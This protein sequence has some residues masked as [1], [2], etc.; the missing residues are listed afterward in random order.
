MPSSFV[1]QFTEREG[2]PNPGLELDR[3]IAQ[4]EPSDLDLRE[5]AWF[6]TR[7]GVQWSRAEGAKCILFRKRREGGIDAIRATIG[8]MSRDTPDDDLVR[9]FYVARGFDFDVWWKVNGVEREPYTSI[10]DV[11]GVSEKSGSRASSTFKGSA[12]FAWWNFDGRALAQVEDRDANI[13]HARCLT[14]RAPAAV[15]VNGPPPPS[16]LFGVDF[17]GGL[18]DGRGNRKI[19]VAKW[20]RSA[21]PGTIHLRHGG[22]EQFGRAHLSRMVVE[23]GGWW[24]FDFPFGIALETAQALELASWDAWLDWCYGDGDLA[25]DYPTRRRDDARGRI[26]VHG[27]ARRRGVDD[28]WGTTWFPLFQQLY[29][30]TIRGAAE[31]LRPLRRDHLHS[32]CVY[33]W[34]EFTGQRS[35]VCEG[36]PGATICRFLGLAATGYKGR[37]QARRAHRELIIARLIER[38]LPIS[39]EQAQRAIADVEGDAVDALVLLESA[40]RASELPRTDWQRERDRLA[41]CDQEIEGW[42]P[43]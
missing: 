23:E 33:P 12:T 5:F 30:Q 29:R 18:E 42:F 1:A 24:V 34:D 7:R 31:V 16:L 14:A 41:E 17:S 8:D 35:V 6:G 4:T 40:R 39:G 25:A 9:D 3:I 26:G 21:L 20:D 27:W 37:G 28:L 13:E 2:L 22:E 43:A 19:W 15:T 11:P 38:G 10:E 32:V 36:F